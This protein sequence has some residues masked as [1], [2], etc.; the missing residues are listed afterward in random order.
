MTRGVFKRFSR[1]ERGL[2]LTEA[3]I[4]LPVVI[5]VIT[6]FIEFGFALFQWNQ[7]V[8]ALQLGARLAAVSDPVTDTSALLTDFA[9]IPAGQD[10]PGFDATD[11]VR[12]GGSGTACSNTNAFNRIY[13]GGSTSGDTQL[14]CDP[15]VGARTPGMCDFN[16][17]LR[18]ENVVFT[19]AR[20]GLGYSARPGP[21]NGLVFTV[22]VETEN[23]TFD[24]PLLGALI[25]V[26]RIEIPALPVTVT[27]EDLTRCR[28]WSA[29][30]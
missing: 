22:T 13:F 24:L 17:F 5:L 19:Y 12:C 9:G 20:S 23:H 28:R 3:V 4:T 10:P 11:V 6:V 18:P 15:N 26:N 1:D 7:T 16:K 27:S 2:S 8:K 30:C 29:G 14:T 21:A 25:G